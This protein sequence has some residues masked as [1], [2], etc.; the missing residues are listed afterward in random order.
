MKVEWKQ[1]RISPQMVAPRLT[2]L[3]LHPGYF[4]LVE[5]RGMVELVYM[6]L[7]DE[8]IH[9]KTPKPSN[10]LNNGLSIK[11]AMRWNDPNANQR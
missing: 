11:E 1:E 6:A 4:H 7:P 8:E 10:K 5:D 3:N 9:R 2:T